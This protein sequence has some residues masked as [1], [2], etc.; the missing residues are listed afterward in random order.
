KTTGKLPLFAVLLQRWV[1]TTLANDEA[2]KKTVQLF[3]SFI[4]QTNS[5]VTNL[6]NLLGSLSTY[7]VSNLGE[8]KSNNELFDSVFNYADK[9]VDSWIQDHFVKNFNNDSEELVNLFNQ[10]LPGTD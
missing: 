3:L 6:G 7:S 10:G 5:G 2:K 9:S 4:Y 1:A 8:I